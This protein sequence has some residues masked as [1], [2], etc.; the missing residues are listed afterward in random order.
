MAS[1][2]SS[3]QCPGTPSPQHGFEDRQQFAHGGDEGQASGFAGL[4]QTAVKALERRV[5]LDRHKA[6]HVERCTDRDA[7]PLN[8][9]LA[10]VSAAVPVRQTKHTP[11]LPCP[12]A[13]AVHN[14]RDDYGRSPECWCGR[15]QDTGCSRQCQRAELDGQSLGNADDGE[16]ACG[17][18]RPAIRASPISRE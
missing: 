5:V 4:G 3:G 14:V 18:G 1:A 7:A 15:L 11:G 6:G 13:L 16:L 10:A 9:A 2:L 17:I 8:L 12:R